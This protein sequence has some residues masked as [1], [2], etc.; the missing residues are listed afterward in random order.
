M[1]SLISFSGRRPSKAAYA[2]PASYRT[3]RAW[4]RPE[5]RR[6]SRSCFQSLH[7]SRESRGNPT[8]GR[9]YASQSVIEAL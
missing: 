3:H 1:L 4:P 6:R 9:A 8:A 7:T 2:L 5:H